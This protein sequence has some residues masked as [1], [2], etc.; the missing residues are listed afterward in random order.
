MN[1]WAFPAAAGRAFRSR[2]DFARQEA[3]LLEIASC[4]AKLRVPLQ[5]VRRG[6]SLT[7]PILKNTIKIK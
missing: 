4:L 2:F 5:P 3:I 6:G 7:Q 1:F